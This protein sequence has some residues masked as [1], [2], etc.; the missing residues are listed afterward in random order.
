MSTPLDNPEGYVD[1]Y[2]CDCSG[3]GNTCFVVR[4]PAI[5]PPPSYTTQKEA[6]KVLRKVRAGELTT[7]DIY[8]NMREVE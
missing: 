7:Q 1:P 8:P 3:V 6:E 2:P 4:H 5:S